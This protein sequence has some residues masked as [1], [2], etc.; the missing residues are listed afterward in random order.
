MEAI[1][2]D[3]AGLATN[4]VYR[5]LLE[6][7]FSFRSVGEKLAETLEESSKDHEDEVLMRERVAEL[8]KEDAIKDEEMRTLKRE[9][10]LLQA[11]YDFFLGGSVVTNR[12]ETV[13]EYLT[14][15]HL[16][17]DLEGLGRRYAQ[18]VRAQAQFKGL[19]APEVVE[20]LVALNNV[21]PS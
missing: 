15:Q 5:I 16:T 13:K 18:V 11:E 9:N 4:E 7:M 19:P 14:G 6:V 12:W 3:G 1:S 2:E 10:E 21:P 20:S 8:I 17:W